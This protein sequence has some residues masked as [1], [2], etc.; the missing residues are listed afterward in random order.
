M[1]VG[2]ERSPNDSGIL[3][4]L[5]EGAR[6]L[7]GTLDPDSAD[8]FDLLFEFERSKKQLEE[9]VNSLSSEVN[10]L[11]ESMSITEDAKHSLEVAIETVK[12]QHQLELDKVSKEKGLIQS[13]NT[14]LKS[15]LET[16]NEQ[17]ARLSESLAKTR[18]NLQQ[19]VTELDTLTSNYEAL[20]ERSHNV[21]VD[22]EDMYQFLRNTCLGIK[23]FEN[24]SIIR[25][26]FKSTAK[27]QISFQIRVDPTAPG[28]NVAGRTISVS[29]IR[30]NSSQY[31]P[32]IAR[33]I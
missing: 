4:S 10:T 27:K 14:K 29:V 6:A 23:Q 24:N 16:L 22:F 33:L 32:G 7:F 11:K 12:E 2:Q 13:S 21:E 31:R 28:S 17:N 5:S 20:K 8:Q 30:I 9:K 1:D 18:D 25:D 19:K 3:I 15:K 26:I